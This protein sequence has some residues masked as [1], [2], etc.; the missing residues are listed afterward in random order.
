VF[1]DVCANYMRTFLSSRLLRSGLWEFLTDVSGRT[2]LQGINRYPRRN[3]PEE[4]RS[5]NKWPVRGIKLY[6]KQ[7]LFRSKTDDVSVLLL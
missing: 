7:V 5:Q 1:S 4:R 2:F 6:C 3:S